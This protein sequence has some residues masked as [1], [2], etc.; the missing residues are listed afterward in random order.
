[1]N[2]LGI[3]LLICIIYCIEQYKHKNRTTTKEYKKLT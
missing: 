1:V 2:V 3:L